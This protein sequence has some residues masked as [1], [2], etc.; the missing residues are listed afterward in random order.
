MSMQ[1]WF[2]GGTDLTPYY[3]DESDAVHFHKTLK[4]A[5]D[6][7][8]KSYYPKFKKWCDNYF[9]IPH[10]GERRGIGGIFFDDLDQPS[11]D[12]AFKF[13]RNCAEAVIPSYLPLGTS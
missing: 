1:W 12:E 7:S 11:Q 13:V 10:R 5:C 3:L 9:S 4:N 8:D 6:S 2:G